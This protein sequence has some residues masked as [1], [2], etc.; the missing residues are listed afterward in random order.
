MI[1][2]IKEG[3]TWLDIDLVRNEVQHIV[4]A[5][6]PEEHPDRSGIKYYLDLDLPEFPMSTTY[7]T[8]IRLEG[9]EKPPVQSAGAL[10]YEGCAFRLEKLLSGRLS[11][12]TPLRN[13]TVLSAVASLTTRYRL[14]EIIEPAMIDR[15]LPARVAM[16]AGLALRDFV[17]YDHNFFSRYQAQVKQFLTWQPDNKMVS[18]KQ[19]EYL[20]FL[21]NFTPLPESICLRIRVTRADGSREVLTKDTISGLKQFQVV[22]CQV[23]PAVLELDPDVVKYDVWLSDANEQ[24]F[25][26][27]RTYVVDRR[28]QAFERFLLFA[29]SFGGFDTIRLLGS[30]S[31]ESD[32]TKSISKKERQ[33][34]YGLDFSEME[35]IDVVENSGIKLSTGLFEQNSSLNLD[36][37]RELLI[38]EVILMDTDYG[39]EAMNLLTSNLEYSKDRPGLVERTLELGRT[40][41][42]KNYSRIP[43]VEKLPGRAMKWVG[44]ASI[45]VL[46]EFGKRT[47]KLT[48]ERLQ[49]VYQDDESKVIPFAVKPNLPGDPDY[50]APVVEGSITPGSTPYPSVEIIRQISFKRNNCATDQLGTAPTV[51]IPAGTYGGL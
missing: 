32:V 44:V 30:S 34:G 24:R 41:N 46:D 10:V 36:Y 18:P 43:A 6:D 26:E 49:R 7:E 29:N 23:G 17:G 14:R 40:Y 4:P 1:D 16:R 11:I 38:S 12:T 48:F 25:S 21:L 2:F 5:L 45:P 51:T 47:G 3:L 20:Y 27:A 35:I 22:C 15:F 9:R 13:N 37:L 31:Q 39:F 33:A 8:L 28:P 19:R 42:D 50:I